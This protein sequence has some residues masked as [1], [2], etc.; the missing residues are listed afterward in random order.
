VHDIAKVKLLLQHGADINAKAK[1]GNTA[2]LIAAV[3]TGNYE[4]VKFLIDHGA[5]PSALNNRKENALIRAASFSDTATIS[6]LLGKGLPIDAVTVDSSVALLNAVMN[7]NRPVVLQLLERGASPDQKCFLGFTPLFAAAIFYDRESAMAL[8]KK[9][10]NIN[11]QDGGGNSLL[12]WATYNEHDDVDFIQAL[13]DKGADVNIKS[14]NGTTVLD[15]AMKKG[16][17]ATVELLKK[18]GAK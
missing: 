1:S 4:S 9:S 16:N 15:W 14:K 2:L 11:A 3:G 6:L 7:V 18:T 5:D 8:L 12:M 10:K 13:L 17:T